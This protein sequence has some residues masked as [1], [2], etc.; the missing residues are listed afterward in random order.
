MTDLM[1]ARAEAQ[2]IWQEGFDFRCCATKFEVKDEYI[3]H[4]HGVAQAAENIAAQIPAMD[5]EKAYVLGLLHDYG[6]KYDEQETG[7]FHARTGYEELKA[8][9]YYEAAKI[10]LTHSFP[11]KNFCDKDYASYSKEW[12]SWA[13]GELSK[14]TYD[15]YDRLIQLCDMFFE[16]MH[17]VDFE[18]RF[19]GIMKR[20]NLEYEDI[21]NLKEG[22][23]RNKRYFESKIN[24]DIY[25]LL[26]IKKL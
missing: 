1:P 25:Q 15:D 6:K 3:F 19:S 8:M 23:E 4:S 16:G 12:L 26:N 18:T 17:M 21:K 20:Y 22:A 24:C 2:K 14:I 9:G 10:C 7:K 11:D 5:S 13:H